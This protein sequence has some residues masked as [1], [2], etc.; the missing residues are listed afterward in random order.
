MG[1]AGGWRR[2]GAGGGQGLLRRGL[3]RAAVSR[4]GR[5][6]GGAG[7]GR[8]ARWKKR[9]GVLRR[10]QRLLRLRGHWPGRWSATAAQAWGSLRAGAGRRPT[11]GQR[12]VCCWQRWGRRGGRGPALQRLL[13]L[14]VAP[15]QAHRGPA[16][17]LL[18]LQRC[19]RQLQRRVL[20]AAARG[21]L[22]V[23]RDGWPALQRRVLQAVA[24]RRQGRRGRQG[25]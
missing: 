10:L 25:G 18:L 5:R 4:R 20:L 23:L 21:R 3:L 2:G 22:L 7:V 1:V 11:A 9:G 19:G 16:L 15:R 6:R 14:A 24:P 12:A 13:L 8:A 17:Q